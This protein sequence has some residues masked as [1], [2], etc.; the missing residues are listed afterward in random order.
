MPQTTNP[1]AKKK[2][3]DSGSGS[4]I[5]AHQNKFAFH[6]NPK[7]KKTATI[8]ASPIQYCCRRCYDKIV[9]RKRYRKYKPLTQP[10]KCNLCQQRNVT[11]AY[12]TICDRCSMHH[13]KTVALL[14]QWN[15]VGIDKEEEEDEQQEEFGGDNVSDNY[16]DNDD[17]D[18][19][20]GAEDDDRR[21]NGDGTVLTTT[22]T[23]TTTTTIGNSMAATGT[24]NVSTKLTEKAGGESCQPPS[25]SLPIMS[26]KGPRYTRV[27]TVC[28]KQPALPD[29]DTT[30][31]PTSSST[32]GD[33]TNETGPHGQPVTLSSTNAG[34]PLKLRQVKSIRRQQE[35]Q[36]FLSRNKNRIRNGP[37]DTTATNND[38]D[39]NNN[40]N[41]DCQDKDGHSR[42]SE[43]SD[44]DDD[45]D[46][47]D[48]ESDEYENVHEGGGND[49]RNSSRNLLHQH[50]QS[51]SYSSMVMNENIGE[52]DDDP[53]V[54]AVGGVQNLLVGEAY[55]KMLLDKKSLTPTSSQSQRQYDDH[56][57]HHH[58]R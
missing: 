26:P 37:D 36:A 10:T 35:K 40:T 33:T 28:C 32:V 43:N 54:K 5:P 49:N 58:H 15:R 31:H 55:Q 41:D 9:W 8:L 46:D 50:P 29:G 24:C 38:D 14:Q 45:D 44:D 47:E 4:R 13:T 11:A 3:K 2:K 16:C 30:I 7:S 42:N 22:T 19:E 25:P 48:Q 27:C 18:E 21:A 39:N 23:T 20:E 12:H 57:H 53:F 34:K 6:H 1:P 51:E 52:D 17:S 56:H